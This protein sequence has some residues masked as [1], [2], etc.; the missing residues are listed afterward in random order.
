[1]LYNNV[2]HIICLKTMLAKALATESNSTFFNITASSI[3]SKFRGDSEKLVKVLFELANFHAP[4][5]IFFDEFDSIMSR[6]GSGNTSGGENNEH[7]GSRRL[8]TELLIQMDGVIHTGNNIFF[9]AASNLPWDI[10]PAFLRR[11][12]K[13][14]MIPMPNKEARTQMIQKNFS[15]HHTL[16]E[17]RHI[18]KCA[19][20]TDGYSGS[21]IQRLC[22]EIAMRQIRRI[23]TEIEKIDENIQK[24]HSLQKNFNL[25]RLL[26]RFPI[27]E[28]DMDSSLKCTRPS[29]DPKL[30][31][32][33]DRWTKEFGST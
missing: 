9:L 32:R 7:E 20:E 6:R 29:T 11:L 2:Q 4:S 27:D 10:D 33:Y 19:L 16:L 21:D 5:T 23:V 24:D 28:H 12:E 25:D 13:R 15:T 14:I 31:S 3:V 1:M 8:K 17:D 30:C 26:K 18:E 22:K